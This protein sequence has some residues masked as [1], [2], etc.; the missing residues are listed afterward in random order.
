[1]KIKYYLI[2]M[3]VLLTSFFFI[4]SQNKKIKEQKF[5]ISMLNTLPEQ[6]SQIVERFTTKDSIKHAVIKE[7]II[8][9]NAEKKVVAGSSYIDSVTRALKISVN[10]INELTKINAQLTAAIKLSDALQVPGA[11]IAASKVYKDKFLNIVYFP[12]SDSVY[13]SYAVN[14]N[15]VKYSKRKWFLGKK[16]NYIDFFSEDKRVTIANVS[17]FQEAIK[18]PGRFGLSFFAGYGLH[19][20]KFQPTFGAGISYNVIRF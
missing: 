18:T 12:E 13:L 1:M 5:I 11:A 6:R 17:R 15:A 4:R 7:Q 9:T 3:T 10:R 20:G 8:K 19:S 2:L 14:L 16:N